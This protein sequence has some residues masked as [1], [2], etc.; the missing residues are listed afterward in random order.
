MLYGFFDKTSLNR[1]GISKGIPR[2]K[3]GLFFPFG[4]VTGA[5][6]CTRQAVGGS[7]KLSKS[8]MR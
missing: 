1:G 3:I 4:G 7:G 5:R 8:M 6:N 2:E